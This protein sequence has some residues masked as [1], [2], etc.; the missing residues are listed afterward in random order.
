MRYIGAA[1]TYGS[2]QPENGFEPADILEDAEYCILVIYFFYKQK[3]SF[4]ISKWRQQLHIACFS[5]KS[6]EVYL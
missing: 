5:G 2:G 4:C 6:R 3:I 1:K